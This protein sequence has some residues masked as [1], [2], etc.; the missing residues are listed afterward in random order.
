MADDWSGLHSQKFRGSIK[1]TAKPRTDTDFLSAG[2]LHGATSVGG[3]RHFPPKYGEPALGWKPSLK[4]IVPADRSGT[5]PKITQ[6]P[7]DT[8]KKYRYFNALQPMNR[9][10]SLA[11]FKTAN[12]G[13]LEIEEVRNLELW[14]ERA[15]KKD[16]I[17]DAYLRL[18]GARSM[19]RSNLLSSLH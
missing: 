17:T 2:F 10:R 15:L 7:C 16:P 12:K 8:Q 18:R 3:K 5:L 19:L 13:D 9:T 1:I 4:K 11:T 6:I 14:E